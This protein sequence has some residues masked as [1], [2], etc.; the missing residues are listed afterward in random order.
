MT[1]FHNTS[2]SESQ[3]RAEL[4]RARATILRALQAT[5]RTERGVTDT[6]IGHAIVGMVEEV[7]R[8]SANPERKAF[9]ISKAPI[10]GKR[11]DLR[12][13]ANHTANR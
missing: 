11:D 6:Q 12:A 1:F 5:D 9:P 10:N 4:N 7:R 13:G 3:A 8:R 2:S